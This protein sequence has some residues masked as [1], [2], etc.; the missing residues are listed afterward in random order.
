MIIRDEYMRLK[1]M[2]LVKF[3]IGICFA[4]LTSKRHLDGCPFIQNLDTQGDYGTIKP[5]FGFMSLVN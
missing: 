1:V 4:K 3:L 2:S 5:H